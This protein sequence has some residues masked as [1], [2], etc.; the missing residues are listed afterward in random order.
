MPK[1]YQKVFIIKNVFLGDQ[2]LDDCME[3]QIQTH[4]REY[5]LG[6][7]ILHTVFD[8][9]CIQISEYQKQIIAIFCRAS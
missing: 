8:S 2:I 4:L 6:S 1:G 9:S 5:Q 7:L 3:I